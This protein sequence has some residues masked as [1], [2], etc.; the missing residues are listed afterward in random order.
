MVGKGQHGIL[1]CSENIAIFIY[2]HSKDFFLIL[3]HVCFTFGE[4]VTKIECLCK[5]SNHWL[6]FLIGNIFL[7]LLS[8]PFENS[9][10]NIILCVKMLLLKKKV[11]CAN[12]D[13]SS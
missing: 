8:T 4:Y 6:Y 3:V 1:N 12:F 9:G 13:D 10:R 7:I 5:Y 2:F 11:A